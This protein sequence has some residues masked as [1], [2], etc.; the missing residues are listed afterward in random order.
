MGHN[1]ETVERLHPEIRPGGRYWRSISLL[2]ASKRM[3]PSTL[4]KSGLMLGLGESDDEI[5]QAMH[6]LREA[7]VDILTLGQYLRPSAQHVPVARWI[8]PE[9]FAEWK[10]VGEEEH[11]FR[12]VEAGP[13]VRSSYHA[14]E[15]AREVEAGGPGGI[16]HVL[17]A[18][19]PAPAEVQAA[20]LV[21]LEMGRPG[22]RSEAT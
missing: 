1:L 11:G 18:D 8:R 13:L 7:A 6:D 14:K 19:V 21:Q 5:R 12:H 10:R 22:T 17:E 9:A 2:G 15:Q 16:R 4:T 20:N 3:D